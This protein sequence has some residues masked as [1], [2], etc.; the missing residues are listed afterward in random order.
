MYPELPVALP[1]GEC[2]AAPENLTST[3]N[4]AAFEYW[5]RIRG[6]RPMPSR[7]DF[8]PAD[9]VSLL[10]HLLLV[11]VQWD[12]LDFRYRLIGTFIVEMSADNTGRW[13]SQIPHQAQPSRTWSACELVATTGRPICADIPYVGKLKDIRRLEDVMMP[14]SDDGARVNMLFISADFL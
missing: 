10:P 6:S 11:D 5:Q 8:N 14:F 13:I 9:V 1:T 7:S 2:H 3:V 12:P 4:Q